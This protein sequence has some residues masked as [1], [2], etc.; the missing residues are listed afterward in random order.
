[1]NPLKTPTS[2]KQHINDR[3]GRKGTPKRDEFDKKSLKFKLGVLFN[4]TRKK[5]KISKEDI[6]ERT[7][8][9]LELISKIELGLVDITLSKFRQ[10]VEVGLQKKL[11]ITIE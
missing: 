1:M 3:F 9:K 7:N 6:A 2:Y 8:T 11:N 4:T 5:E 10:L